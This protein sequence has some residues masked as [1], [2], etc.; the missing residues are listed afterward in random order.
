[1][2]VG[3]T[4][5]KIMATW[6]IAKDTFY[7]WLREKPEFKEAHE[8]G[9]VMCQSWWEDRV[10]DSIN[11]K[12]ANST[13]LLAMMNNKFGWARNAGSGDQTNN[14]VNIGKLTINNIQNLNTDELREKIAQHIQ[15]ISE[16]NPE[17]LQNLGTNGSDT[18]GSS[19]TPA[20]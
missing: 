17:L 3:A 14:T 15:V 11:N 13:L 1:M 20:A 2:S 12:F 5:T 19:G 7:R 4:D 10:S 16:S 8:R 9:L 6:G 18:E